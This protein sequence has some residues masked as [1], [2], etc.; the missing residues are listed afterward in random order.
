MWQRMV[1]I[2]LDLHRLTAITTSTIITPPP[3]T[4]T[5]LTVARATTSAL[6]AV[7]LLPWRRGEVEG[8]RVWESEDV[9]CVR[10]IKG[11]K[12]CG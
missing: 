9:P 10:V 12:L 1:S 2:S 3:I 4:S 5:T 7:L 6:S 11:A 8:V